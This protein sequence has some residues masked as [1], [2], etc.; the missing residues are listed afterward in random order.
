MWLLAGLF[1]MD[2]VENQPSKQLHDNEKK[3][4][5]L[6]ISVCLCGSSCCLPKLCF[7]EFKLYTTQENQSSSIQYQNIC[8]SIDSS[9]LPSKTLSSVSKR[10]VRMQYSFMSNAYA[11]YLYQM[12]LYQMTHVVRRKQ[13]FFFRIDLKFANSVSI[14][15]NS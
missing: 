10:F 6:S 8:L 5:G 9:N 7:R 1:V 12:Y 4:H 13:V 14:K 3:S 11:M 15:T 2:T